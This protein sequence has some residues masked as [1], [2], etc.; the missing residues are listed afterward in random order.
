MRCC[1]TPEATRSPPR[2]TGDT[3]R[4]SASWRDVSVLW[5]FLLAASAPAQAALAPQYQRQR[6]L[7]A[8]VGN[9]EVLQQIGMIE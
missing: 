7:M 9:P 3:L 4:S 1:R 2:R 6:E 5:F 8:I